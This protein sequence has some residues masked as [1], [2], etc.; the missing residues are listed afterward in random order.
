MLKSVLTVTRQVQFSDKPAESIVCAVK[1][2]DRQEVLTAEELISKDV[3]GA[4]VAGLSDSECALDSGRD[5]A[6]NSRVSQYPVRLSLCV[7]SIS[8]Q[9]LHC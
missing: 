6:G 3:Q 2:I 7:T 1:E 9:P 8:S 4:T 5:C